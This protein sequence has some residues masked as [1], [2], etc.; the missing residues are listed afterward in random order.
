MSTG[1]LGDEN[2]AQ[3]V[4][5]YVSAAPKNMRSKAISKQSN[6]VGTGHPINAQ[7]S[8]ANLAFFVHLL[9]I[10]LNF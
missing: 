2:I 7:A 9:V 5:P 1:F 4:A 6:Q 8:N 3:H 10:D